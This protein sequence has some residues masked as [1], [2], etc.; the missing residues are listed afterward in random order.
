[1]LVGRQP[2]QRLHRGRG[3][4]H[5]SGAIKLTEKR[6]LHGHFQSDPLRRLQLNHLGQQVDGLGASFEVRAALDEL[7][8]SVNVPLG[9]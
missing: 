8:V 9:E 4:L 5:D 2:G 6:M 7:L 3:L 1:M